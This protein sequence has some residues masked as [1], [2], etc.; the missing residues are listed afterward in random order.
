MRRLRLAT[1]AVSVA[2]VSLLTMAGAASAGETTVTGITRATAVPAATF[3]LVN[4]PGTSAM[5]AAPTQLLSRYGYV[6]QEYYV[7][8][9]ACRY[10]ITNPLG[11]AQVVDCGWRYKTRMIVR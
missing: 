9:T 3:T 1:I 6:E 8:G 4:V 7:T 5:S 11:T 2:A 10:R